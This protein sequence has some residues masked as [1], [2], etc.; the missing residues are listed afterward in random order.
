MCEFQDEPQFV[1]Y[2]LKHITVHP[3]VSFF[4]CPTATC[5]EIA[6]HD[7]VFL[8]DEIGHNADAVLKFQTITYKYLRETLG[9]SI[10]HIVEFTDGCVAQYKSKVPFYRISRSE[11]TFGCTPQRCYFGSHH[12]K[13]PAD[14]VNGTVKSVLS[15]AVRCREALV[16]DSAS[17]KELLTRKMSKPIVADECQH[18]NMTFITVGGIRR[19]ANHS[20]HTVKGTCSLHCV[21]SVSPTVISTRNLACFCV[22]CCAEQLESCLN[23]AYVD[24]CKIA[25]LDGKVTEEHSTQHADALER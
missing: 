13:G 1:H 5:N 17:A 7:V 18:K 24:P 10:S 2:S 16:Y 25:H 6:R 15:E 9:L 21:A 23:K 12:G 20:L 14:A 11:Q 8:S 3:V 19:H 22:N 4:R